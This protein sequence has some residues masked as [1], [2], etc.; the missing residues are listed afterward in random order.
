MARKRQVVKKADKISDEKES[1]KGEKKV[2]K[3]TPI[4]KK[5]SPPPTKEKK[6]ELLYDE[7]SNKRALKSPA[8]YATLPSSSSMVEDSSKIENEE[9]LMDKKE[10]IVDSQIVHGKKDG[11]CHPA[12]D[13]TESSTA[14]T[15]AGNDDSDEKK[16]LKNA[17]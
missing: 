9:S 8:S 4:P 16:N 13:K 2:Q 17:T 1:E 6:G 12:T 11:S 14:E 10:S 7:K 5:K 15:T 3:T